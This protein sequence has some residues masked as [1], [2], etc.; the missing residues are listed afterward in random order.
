MNAVIEHGTPLVDDPD[1]VGAGRASS[2]STRRRCCAPTANTRP[3]YATG[4]VDLDAHI[5]IDMVEGNSA[6][7]LRRWT[8]QRRPGLARRHQGRGHRSGRVVSG[9]GCPRTS[10]TPRRVADPFHVVR[11]ANRCV[12]QV[13]R[14]VQNET[15][16]PSRPQ[17]RPAVSDPQAAAHRQR[18]PRRTRPPTGCCSACASVTPTTRCSAPGWPR[19][20][21]ATST[22]PTT[23]ADA[24]MLLDKA[25][26]GCA[27]DDVAEI[28]SLGRDA[29][30]VAHRDPR[31]PRHRRVQR[32]DRG[33]QPVREE[34]EAMRPRLPNLRA[35]P[36][37][38]APPRRRRHLARHDPH[39][40]ASEPALPT[41][42][43]RAAYAAHTAA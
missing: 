28:R 35:L 11:V 19:N 21:C 36:A 23:R 15:L 12:D 34:G 5:M 27:D 3:S 29:R 2:A 14:R 41:Q 31:P 24:A 38:R 22:S 25:I 6:A 18:T 33:P 43:R 26:V 17:A 13:R 39:H 4:L 32:P 16:R 9:P 20:R 30:V 10:I 42:T 1:R 7:D 40:H 37:P 8:R